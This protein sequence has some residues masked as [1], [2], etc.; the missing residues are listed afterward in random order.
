MRIATLLSIGLILLI[1]GGGGAGCK[2]KPVKV[3]PFQHTAGNT[4]HRIQ[5]LRLKLMEAMERNDLRYVHDMMNYFQAMLASL[6]TGL[7]GERKQRVDAVVRDL[8]I[9]AQQID[10]SAGR[11]NQAAT[12]ANLQKLVESLKELEGEFQQTGK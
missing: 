5:E 1:A 2:R 3:E 6:S 12:Q 8:R 11:G 7:E 4:Y 9:I 10:N